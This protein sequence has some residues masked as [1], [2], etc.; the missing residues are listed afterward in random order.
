MQGDAHTAVGDAQRTTPV[1]ETLA[2]KLLAYGVILA[3][4]ITAVLTCAL[5]PIHVDELGAL[6]ILGGLLI[7]SDLAR[8]SLYGDNS[9]SPGT[10]AAL[11]AGGLVGL[12]AVALL[13]ALSLLVGDI[14]RRRVNFWTAFN[15]SVY[16]L[17]GVGGSALLIIARSHGI[18]GFEY[19][20][21]GAL[22]GLVYYAI[23]ISIVTFAMACAEGRRVITVFRESTAWLAPHHS[24]YGVLAAGVVI[25]EHRLG[26]LGI[27]VFAMPAAAMLVA[28]GQ[29][30]RATE[31]M[32]EQLREKNQTLEALLGENRGLLAS[33]SRGHLQLIRGLAQ[34]IDAKDPYTAGHTSRV[35]QYSVRIAGAL[36]LDDA[37][38]REIEHGALL[39]DIGKIGVPD[40]VLTKPGP[41]DD[42]EWE[43][44]RRHPLVACAIL[45]GVE[46][47]PTVISMVRSHHENL[48][49]TGYPDHLM[50]DEL[51]LPARIARV[52]DAFDAMTSDRPYRDALSLTVARA[53]LRRNV[54][55]QFCPVIV[56]AFED[57]IERGQLDRVLGERA[58]RLAERKAS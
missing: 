23:N 7:L 51:S 58:P 10:V 49:G 15:S 20:A 40:A 56:D 38:R 35:A 8:Q 6:A 30:I 19:L 1:I 13:E 31:G 50:G 24:V 17:A 39:H 48:D 42:E 32:V 25:A 37:T 33:L 36:G 3:A 12:P 47:S 44:M 46:L 29:Y 52:A 26:L 9:L 57:L 41:L 2:F 34:A 53:E 14:S 4:V 11:A 22:S 54:G 16:A 28:T 21:V 27:I 45:D 43:A 18:G 5:A 55:T